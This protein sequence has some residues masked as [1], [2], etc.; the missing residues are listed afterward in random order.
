MR[1]VVFVL[2]KMG[3][4]PVDDVLVL[5]ASDDFDR[6]TATTANLDIDIEY[7]FQSLG[8]GHRG[9]LFGGSANLRIFNL[10]HTFTALCWRDQPATVVIRC[11]N[12]MV[13]GF[14]DGAGQGSIVTCQYLS[15]S[16]FGVFS[17]LKS[18]PY[19]T[20]RCSLQCVGENS[21]LRYGC[22]NM[23]RKSSGSA[24]KRGKQCITH[25]ERHWDRDSLREHPSQRL[26]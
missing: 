2:L 25:E 7:T 18:V 21:T 11:E 10:L 13:T 1:G 3:Q 26:S 5:D 24:G 23:T 9:M 16:R 12:A 14:P 19:L 17:C 20:S 15:E 8:P 6:S 4:D 22:S